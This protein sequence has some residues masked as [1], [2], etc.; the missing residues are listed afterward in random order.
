MPRATPLPEKPP[1]AKPPPP[2]DAY[3]DVAPLK[4]G[5]LKIQAIAWSPVAQDRMAVVNSRIVN[6]GDKVDGFFVVAIRRDD[7]VVREKGK[8]YRVI[9]GRP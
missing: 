8:V 1:A 9:F 2:V 3:K 7:L 4:D 5:R 6:E